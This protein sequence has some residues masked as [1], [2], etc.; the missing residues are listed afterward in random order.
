MLKQE[1]GRELKQEVIQPEVGHAAKL[2]VKP[3][4]GQ[5]E[6]LDVKKLQ[7]IPQGTKHQR[8]IEAQSDDL[9]GVGGAKCQGDS[10][11]EG[12]GHGGG[13]GNRRGQGGRGGRRGRGRG[14]G[15][16]RGRGQGKG[17]NE[18]WKEKWTDPDAPKE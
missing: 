4:V 1:V 12:E 7:Q 17:S 15:S 16:W 14:R 9:F 10:V 18:W 2:D 13:R 6:D 11:V 3:Q 5:N 8:S